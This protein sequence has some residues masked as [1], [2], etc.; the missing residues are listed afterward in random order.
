MVAELQAFGQTKKDEAQ[1]LYEELEVCTAG[2]VGPCCVYHLSHLGR[3][4][5]AQLL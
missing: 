4:G 5:A 2:L 1:Q 3:W